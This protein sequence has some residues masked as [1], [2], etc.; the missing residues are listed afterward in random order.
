MINLSNY[1]QKF[2]A[3]LKD[4][5]ESNEKIITIINSVCASSLSR[6]AVTLKDNVVF[7]KA[8]PHIKSE[9]FMRKA[10]ILKQFQTETLL[11]GIQTIR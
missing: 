1:L 6:E 2:S 8:P 10:H 11:E 5:Q 3:I 4:G 9:I 7:I